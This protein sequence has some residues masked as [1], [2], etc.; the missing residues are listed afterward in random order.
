MGVTCIVDVQTLAWNE[1]DPRRLLASF[2]LVSRVAS[3][4][5]AFVLLVP[6]LMAFLHARIDLVHHREVFLPRVGLTER[7]IG[8]G[9]AGRDQHDDELD[10][11]S[12]HCTLLSWPH[13]YSIRSH[14]HPIKKRRIPPSILLLISVFDRSAIT[15]DVYIIVRSCQ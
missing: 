3:A 8:S 9:S 7:N 2:E 6:T 12:T 4:W 13:V 11:S 15:G 10:Y 14:T 1:G 5:K